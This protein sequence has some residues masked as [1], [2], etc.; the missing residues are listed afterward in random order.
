MRWLVAQSRTTHA[1]LDG[2]ESDRK[3]YETLGWIGYGAGAACI[4]TG[5]ILYYLGLRAGSQVAPDVAFVPILAPD[6][7]VAALGGRF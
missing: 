7:A 4:A 3:T 5:G 6:R 2:K 1:R